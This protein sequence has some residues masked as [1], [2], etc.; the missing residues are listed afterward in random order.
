MDKK[1]EAL[2]SKSFVAIIGPTGVGK[3]ALAESLG[4]FFPIH[5]INGDMAQL[6]SPLTIGTAK[7]EWR[8][9]S[10]THYLFDVLNAPES[11]SAPQYRSAVHNLL[12]AKA[13]TQDIPLI[14]GG[15]TL[16]MW[17]LFF[18]QA[19]GN[20]TQWALEEAK[21]WIES[22][23][24]CDYWSTLH[25]IDQERAAALHPNDTYRVYRALLQWRLQGKRP[26]T[27]KP[28]FSPLAKSLIIHIDK[29]RAILRNDLEKRVR[30]ML[31]NGWIQEVN[32]LY[33]TPWKKFWEEK[34]IIG[35]QEIAQFLEAG[36]SAQHIDTL[37][38]AIT[39]KTVAYAKKQATFWRMLRQ[40][41]NNNQAHSSMEYVYIDLT[42]STPD[43][44]IKQLC[45]QIESRVRAL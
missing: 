30:S 35:Y 4:K 12:Q 16:Y 1:N 36:M 9:S 7:P 39:Q 18:A 45:Q 21:Q 2:T 27:F 5:I 13:R 34:K 10:F 8:S 17:S 33:A 15:S 41:L 11:Y 44:Y 28:T 42:F 26:S 37:V 6:Y 22:L 32:N 29:E 20:H 40:K 43:L 38:S 19:Q 14:V 3:T 24:P 25:A 23:Q 31:E